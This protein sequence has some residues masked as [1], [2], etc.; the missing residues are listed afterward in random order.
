MQINLPWR[1]KYAK[2]GSEYGFNLVGHSTY[3]LNEGTNTPSSMGLIFAPNVVPSS[4]GLI[5]APNIVP[6]ST[7]LLL[8]INTGVST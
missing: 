4:T 2:L 1:L 3:T 8:G 7:G 5:I 6:S